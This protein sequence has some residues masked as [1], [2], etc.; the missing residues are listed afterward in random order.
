MAVIEQGSIDIIAKLTEN[1]EKVIFGK[2]DVIRLC[3]TGLLARG[4]ILIED[5]PG[6][7]KTTLAQALARSIDCTFTRIQFTNDMLPSDIIGVSVLNPKTSDFDFRAGPIFANVVLADEIN[8]TPPKTQSA[9]LEAMGENQVS[10][11][12]ISR[13]VPQPFIVLAT[14]NPVEFEGAYPLPESQ[15]DR[16]LLRVEI[17]YPPEDDELRIMRRHD[18]KQALDALE[19]VLGAADVVALQEQVE[20]VTVDDDVARYMLAI[21]QGTRNDDR[22][23]LGVS[24]RA[25]LGLFESCQARALIEGRDYVTPD[26]VK[27]M[28]VPVL[29]HRLLVKSRGSDMAAAA[30]ERARTLA[31]VV[32]RIPVPV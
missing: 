5:I 11:D 32:Q 27:Q 30:R 1:I 20:Q 12:G 24:P 7:G 22:I 2:S 23:Q 6:I 4:H 25:S 18:P 29:A 14:Q 17:G 16:F 19:P 8:R 26:D 10:V 13:P 15:I 3:L 28:A 9:L 21:I 31:D